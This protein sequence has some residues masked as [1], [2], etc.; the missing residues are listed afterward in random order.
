[1]A[2]VLLMQGGNYRF[3]KGVFQYSGGVAALPGFQIERARFR[4]PLP[5]A[6]GFAAIK[7]HL[8]AVGQP[9]QAFCSCELRSPE[10]FT[11]G[12]FAEFNRLYV[13]TLERWGIMRNDL[14]PIARTNV[15][16]EI[17]KPAGP[18]FYA[19]SY[20]RSA[21]DAG[22]TTFVASGSAEAPEG[23]G[24]YR[25]NTI[26]LGDTS[27]EGLREKAHWVL[28][29]MERRMQA[30]GF[31]WGNATGTHLYTV[32]DVHPFLANEFVRRG[33]MNSGLSWHFTRP[34]VRDLELEMDVRGVQNELVL[35]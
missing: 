19:F 24:S 2:E 14:N 15:C 16:P 33:A 4:R 26:R 17:D 30:L 10:P 9:L 31:A 13:G 34:P 6:E 8:Q 28:G 29:E 5:L 21:V 7:A 20:T 32:H 3:I 25:D 18:S 23:N 22:G 12:G 1:M 35:G 11:E 27:E